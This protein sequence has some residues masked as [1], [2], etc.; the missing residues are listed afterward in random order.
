MCGSKSMNNGC[1][2][3]PQILQENFCGNLGVAEEVDGIDVWVGPTTDDYFQGTFEVF[4]AGSTTITATI[5]PTVGPNISFDIPPNFSVAQSANNPFSFHI[6]GN[7]SI[8]SKFC[9][10]L[11]KRV[12]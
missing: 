2:P 4:N 6:A 8:D 1:C 9:V 5:T 12:Y 3:S 7:N 10:T 11:Y